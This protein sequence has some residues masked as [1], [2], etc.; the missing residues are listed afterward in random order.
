MRLTRM[1]ISILKDSRDGSLEQPAGYEVARQEELQLDAQLLGLERHQLEVR[2]H[3]GQRGGGEQE[4]EQRGGGER[5][6]QP[7]VGGEALHVGAALVV[8]HEGGHQ[9]ARR[10]LQQGQACCVW[11]GAG[12]GARQE[13]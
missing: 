5:A 7:A 12:N 9:H 2:G 3:V 10:D 4:D 13:G 1:Y 6:S 8:D 11:D